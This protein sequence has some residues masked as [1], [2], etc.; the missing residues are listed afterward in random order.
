MEKQRQNQVFGSKVGS[1]T[2]DR[3]RIDEIINDASGLRSYKVAP[4]E[5][6][7]RMNDCLKV[8]ITVTLTQ[9]TRRK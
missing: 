3:A 9:K 5:K 4:Q 8:A 2:I 1:T 7:D 6:A